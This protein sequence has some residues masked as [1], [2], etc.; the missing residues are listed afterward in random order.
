MRPTILKP[1]MVF[2]FLTTLG[3]LSKASGQISQSPN[4]QNQ[5]LECSITTD[6]QM[7]SSS[8]TMEV[9]VDGRQIASRTIGISQSSTLTFACAAGTH[10]L[11]LSVP[12]AKTSC[13]TSFVVTVSKTTFRSALADTSNGFLSCKIR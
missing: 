5:Q 2:I 4:L 7:W 10:K 9:Q 1:E 8:A 11:R 12:K 13:T 3:Y 6:P